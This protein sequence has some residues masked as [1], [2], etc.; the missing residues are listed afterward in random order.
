MHTNPSNN[1]R[2]EILSPVH[3]GTN[4][5]KAWAKNI[6]FFYDSQ[7]QKVFIVRQEDLYK[8]LYEF[9]G[10]QE[11][12]TYAAKLAGGNLHD[13]KKF[14]PK[15]LSIHKLAYLSFD[16]P[17]EPGS[18]IKPLLRTGLGKPIIPGSSIKGGIRSAILSHLIL[19]NPGFV[20]KE[21]H[22]GR[23]KGSKI[24]YNDQQLNAHYLGKDPNHDLLRLLQVGDFEIANTGCHKT[25]TLNL[26]GNSWNVKQSVSNYLE[27]AQVGQSSHSRIQISQTQLQHTKRKGII[28]NTDILQPP[29]LF[30]IIHTHTRNLLQYEI[31]FWEEEVEEAKVHN[32]VYD[33]LESLKNLREDIDALDTQKACILRIAAGS[34]WGFMTGAWAKDEKVLNDE[35]WDNLKYTL[36]HPRYVETPFPKSRKIVESGQPLGFIKLQ[37]V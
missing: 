17:K 9:G 28:Q 27:C 16:Y 25:Q 11:L 24:F 26:Y 34:G 31:E 2:L 7:Q 8:A 35:K 37:W 29:Q 30:Q 3:I 15:Q 23:K 19:E 32:L 18:E 13:L 33:Y 20:Q 1:I 36:R 6:D 14:I 4:Q 12:N 21:E 22:L 5:E 10:A